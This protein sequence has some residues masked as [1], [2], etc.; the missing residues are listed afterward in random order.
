MNPRTEERL[1]A[2]FEAKADQVIEER[3][4]RRAAPWHRPL[5]EDLDDSSASDGFLALAGFTDHEPADSG[6]AL[7]RL[8]IDHP[9]GS[10]RHARWFAPALAAAAVVAV[11]V[12]VTAVS[13]VAGRDASKPANQLSTPTPGLTATPSLTPTSTP[14]APQPSGSSPATVTAP[15]PLLGNGKQ[16]GRSE[17]PWDEVGPGWHL[18]EI[19]AA[20]APALYLINPIGGRYLIGQLPAGN[21]L[22]A[23][24]P[25][26]KRALLQRDSAHRRVFTELELATGQVLPSFDAGPDSYF[27]GYSRPKGRAI[28]INAP[29]GKQFTLQRFG[30]DGQR[31]LTYPSAVAG[32]GE[33]VRTWVLYSP[34]GGELLM[35]AANGVAL[36]ANDGHLI[37]SLTAPAGHAS[38]QPLK[39]W[40][41]SATVL[42]SCVNHALKNP[43][44]SSPTDLYLQPVAGGAPTKLASGGGPAAPFGFNNAWRYSG[45]VLLREGSGCGPGELDVLRDGVISKLALPAGI[46]D[47][48]PLLSVDGDVVTVRSDGGCDFGPT[49]VVSVNIV[50]GAMI[51]LFKGAGILLPYPTR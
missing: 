27:V 8:D 22:G 16:A 29:A 41:D 11:A 42:V 43:L 17:I 46:A 33:L 13:T 20:E 28:L 7:T 5:I 35:G 36:L 1:R 24:S 32:L 47:P 51:T 25:D 6:A 40:D 10:P 12:G 44:Y 48:A 3:L 2:A 30:T 14:P 4:D 37:R 31:Q 45:G 38:C 15:A 23:W 19:G 21:R 49:S 18:A 50:T 9:A 34:D 39:W 26:G